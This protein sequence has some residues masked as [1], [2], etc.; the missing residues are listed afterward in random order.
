MLTTL[1]TLIRVTCLGSVASCSGDSGTE[2]QVAGTPA[3]STLGN[4]SANSAGSVSTP[5]I[6]ALGGSAVG[7]ASGD[8]GSMQAGAGGLAATAGAGGQTPAQAGSAPVAGNGGMPGAGGAAPMISCA[9]EPDRIYD[10]VAFLAS[11][12]CRGRIPGDLGNELA[13]A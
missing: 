9:V 4:G 13:L 7:G 5:S 10:D 6:S 1:S 12:D 3:P 8:E 11:D 2:R